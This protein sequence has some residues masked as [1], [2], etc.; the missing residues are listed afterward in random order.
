MKRSGIGGQ[1]GGAPSPPPEG[2]KASAHDQKLTVSKPKLAPVMNERTNDNSESSLLNLIFDEGLQEALPRIAEILL[3]AAMLIERE[4]HIGAAPHQRGVERNGYANGFKP[5]TFQTG[6][7]ALNL[8]LPQVRDS[9][10]PF[11]TSLLEKGSRSDKA[12]KSAI[13]T[14]Y[15]EGVSTRRVTK[16]M[17]QMCGFEVS[18]GQVSNLNKQLDEEFEKWRTRPLP[19]IAYMTLDATYYKVRIDGTVRDCATLIAHGVRRDDGKR[20]ILGVSCA[21]SEAE[22]H[23]RDFLTGLKERGM[24]IPDLITSDAHSGLKAALK[25]SFN[26]SPWQRCQF[27]LQQNAQDHITKQELKSPIAT[28]IKTIFNADSREHAEERLRAFVKKWQD[29]QPKIA[30]WAEEN[31]PEG[32]SI[33]AFPEAHRRRLRTSNA[34]ENVNGQIKK[35]T[36]VVGLFPSEESLLRLVTGVLIEISETWETGK[37]YLKFS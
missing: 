5:R 33:F 23:W 34:C 9:Q 31:L 14:M 25:T 27:H 36:K 20:M 18:S 29:E 16:I 28:E 1:C 32:F 7:G 35:R 13:A 8:A 19:E 30:A 10:D 21:L 26:T 22:V 17:E 12:L 24:G 4:R 6:I 2:C 15:I 3:N 37:A 11:R